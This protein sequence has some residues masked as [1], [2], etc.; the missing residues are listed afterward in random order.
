MHML[1]KARHLEFMRALSG[2]TLTAMSGALSVPFA[3]LAVFVDNRYGQ[4]LFM[5]MAFVCVW[6]A[7]Y[8]V[9]S[10]ERARVSSLEHSGNR[11]A[12]LDEISELREQLVSPLYSP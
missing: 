9:W 1:A 4:L 3:G 12:L 8:R 10:T 11:Q 7:A 5:G 2:E 6:Y